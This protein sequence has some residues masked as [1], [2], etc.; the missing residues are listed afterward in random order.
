MSRT[1]GQ[2]NTRGGVVVTGA[3]TGIGEATALRLATMGYTVFGGVR[4]DEDGRRLVEESDGRVRPVRLEVT[5]AVEI[6]AA[7]ETVTEVLAGER[8]AGLVNNAGIALAS[9]LEFVPLDLLRRQLEVNTVAPVA[10]SQAFLPM[11]RSSRGRIVHIGSNS[12]LVSAPFFGPYCA[13]KFALEAL[14]TAMRMELRRWGIEVSIVDPGDIDTPIWGKSQALADEV[15]ASMPPEADALYGWAVPRIR[16]AAEGSARAGIPADE[17]AK[18]VVVAL[19]ARRPRARYMVGRDA[20][21]QA[22]ASRVL[23]QRTMERLILQHLKI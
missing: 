19:T 21:V 11:L 20:K 12:G 1:M 4:R 16:A 9:P 17:V 3:S 15:L 5:D 13:S 8:L 18:V 7:K 2:T 14:S 23:P 6:A 10:V 22:A